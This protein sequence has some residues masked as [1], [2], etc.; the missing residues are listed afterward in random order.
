MSPNLVDYFEWDV[1]TWARSIKCWN[2]FLNLNPLKPN[3]IALEIGGRRGGL[4][5]YLA[6]EFAVNT[7]CSDLFNPANLAQKLHL[8]YSV[9]NL[10]TYDEQNCLNLSYA[11]CSFDI[12]IFKSVIGA[13]GSREAQ[14]KAISEIYRCL[15]PGGVLLFAENGKS[16]WLH[17]FLR[18]KFNEWSANYWYYPSL[19]EIKSYLSDFSKI[20]V[21]TNG[22]IS[23]FFRNKYLKRIAEYLDILLVKITP[24]KFHYVIYG[25]A[26]K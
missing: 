10:V 13:L 22:F 21:H 23:I 17:N 3:S 7:I 11:D 2:H 20:E 6:H 14:E 16:T 5:L 4:S 18:K 25:T 1:F 12:I 19:Y 15:K 9:E 8:K 24:S 26:I